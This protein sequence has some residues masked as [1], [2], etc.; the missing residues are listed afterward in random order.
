MCGNVYV[1]AHIFVIFFLEMFVLA[2]GCCGVY[3]KAMPKKRN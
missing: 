3:I 2:A 1:P